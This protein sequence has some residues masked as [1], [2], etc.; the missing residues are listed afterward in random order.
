VPAPIW[1]HGGEQA[2][3]VASIAMSQVTGARAPNRAAILFVLLSASFITAADNSIVNVAVPAIR[4]NLGISGGE[5]QFAV[6]IY[7]ITF[8][9]LLITGARLGDLVGYRRVFLVGLSVFSAASLACGLAPDAIWLIVGR[10]VQGLGAALL[11][12]Q[13][14]SGIQL[15]FEGD[16]RTRA[17]GLYSL[18]LAGG[19]AAGQVLG[20]AVVSL[21][22]FGTS[23]RPVF[24]VNV[25]IGLAAIAGGLRF[26]PARRGAR[27]ARLDLGGVATLCLSILLFLV[28][29]MVGR[30]AGWPIWAWL[31]LAAAAPALVLFVQWE[32]H[33]ARGGGYPLL[34]L[35]V[36]RSPVVAWGLLAQT[37]ATVTFSGLLFVL[38]LY[39]QDGLGKSALYSGLALLSWI[40][41]F[42][43]AGSVLGWLPGR[44]RRVASPVGFALLAAA[45][46]VIGV[47]GVI[48]PPDGVFLVTMLGVGGLGIGWGFTAIVDQMAAFVS[49]DD[50]ADLSGLIGTNSEVFGAV[51]IATFGSLYLTI[52]PA[53]GLEAALPAFIAVLVGSGV[54]ALAAASAAYRSIDLKSASSSIRTQAARR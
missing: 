12:P 34:D 48:A 26:L 16:D 30:E 28:P 9:L 22:L 18:A 1:R 35:E 38:A 32:R 31:S 40:I 27:S 6:A 24:L 43:V 29:L 47:S 14:L 20:G 41:A 8:A 49:P 39:L 33:V 19:T 54:A 53:H 42:G 7:F 13:V 44:L 52:A 50:A 3:I 17:V 21:D 23:W 46:F 37:F 51:G 10:G 15:D 11:A 4:A 5:V 25:P 2:H 36:V 45:Y